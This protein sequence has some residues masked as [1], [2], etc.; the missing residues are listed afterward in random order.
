MSLSAFIDLDDGYTLDGVVPGQ[1]GAYP[2]IAF[3]YRPAIQEQIETFLAKPSNLP[4]QIVKNRAEFL[5]AHLRSWD[6]KDRHGNAVAITVENL[7]RIV[8]T[9]VAFMVNAVASTGP[10]GADLGN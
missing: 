8:S 9:V 1:P 5:Y 6:I 2:P 7:S 4:A 10:T 3:T